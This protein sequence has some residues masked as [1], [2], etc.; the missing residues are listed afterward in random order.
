MCMLSLPLQLG[1][2][3]SLFVLC[4]LLIN[5]PTIP[6]LLRWTGLTEASVCVFLLVEGGARLP[7]D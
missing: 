1:L 4:T 5:A 6:A 7:A 2:W 3:T